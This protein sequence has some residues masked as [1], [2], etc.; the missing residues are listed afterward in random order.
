[1]LLYYLSVC[2]PLQ[3]VVANHHLWLQFPVSAPAQY[4]VSSIA[5]TWRG[6]KPQFLGSDRSA[7]SDQDEGETISTL[8]SHTSPYYAGRARSTSHLPPSYLV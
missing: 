7:Q 4:K 1:M 5:G 3:A 6:V 2:P 8:L